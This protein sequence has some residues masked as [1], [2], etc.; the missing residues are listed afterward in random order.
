MKI[1]QVN[2]QHNPIIK[3]SSVRKLLHYGQI[4]MVSI[5][6][7][8]NHIIMST[9]HHQVVRKCNSSGTGEFTGEN[10]L[11][12]PAFFRV[13][14]APGVAEVGSLFPRVRG[15][16]WESCQQSAHGTV[17][18]A[19]RLAL[20]N[21]VYIYIIYYIIYIYIIYFI[22]IYI[23]YF[24]YIYIFDCHVRS[25]FGRWVRQN[26]HQTV[27]QAWFHEKPWRIEGRSTA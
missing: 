12:N 8:I 4:A 13:N 19:A 21:V 17:A 2:I 7:H 5:S 20:Q 9:T 25:T 3:G 14:L 18:R 11:R 26:V 15:S 16:S 23:I 10:T 22:Y 24:I 27:E 6:N 1:A